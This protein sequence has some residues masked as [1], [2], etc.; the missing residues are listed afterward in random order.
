MR[1]V[2]FIDRQNWMVTGSVSDNISYCQFRVFPHNSLPNTIPFT[3]KEN[4][5]VCVAR[6]F[7]CVFLK[8]LFLFVHVCVCVHD[9][10]SVVHW[11]RLLM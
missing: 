10:F 7:V 2:R 3:C 4:V 6:A 8:L 1:A 11:R 9:F 5:C